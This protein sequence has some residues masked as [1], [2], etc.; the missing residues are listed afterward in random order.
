M[1]MV[2]ILVMIAVAMI[3]VGIL[4]LATVMSTSVSER[5]REFAVMRTLGAKNV[6]IFSIIINESLLIALGSFLVA[7]PIA[8]IFSMLMVKMLA[9]MTME[10]L[11]VVVSVNGVLSWLCIVVVGAVLAATVPALNA[12]RFTIREVLTYS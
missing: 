4:S 6:T 5:L 1:I 2:L 9:G 8:G 7:L 10:P 12:M 11:S 3:L